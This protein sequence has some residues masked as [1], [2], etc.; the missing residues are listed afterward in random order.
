VARRAGVTFKI[1]VAATH[2]TNV[3]ALD[4]PGAVM[5]DVSAT[6]TGVTK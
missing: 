6:A 4:P 5:P 3:P 1:T 2:L